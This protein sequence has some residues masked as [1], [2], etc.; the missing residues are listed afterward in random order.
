MSENKPKSRPVTSRPRVG[1]LGTGFISDFHIRCLKAIPEVELSAVCDTDPCK[2]TACKKRWDIPHLFSSLPEMLNSGS[3][4]VVHVL[5]PPVSH[6]EAALTC[7]EHGVDVF[8]EKP[9]GVSTAECDR[10]EDCAGRH[11]RTIGVN[12][13]A[14]H[15]PAFLRL[16]KMIET[17]RLGNIEHVTACINL[18]LRQLSA[19]QHGHWMFREFGNIILE[20][21]PHPLSQ[22]QFLL[23]PIRDCSAVVSGRRRLNT[24]VAFHDTWQISLL[25][26]RGTAQLLLSFGRDYLENSL[27]VIGQDGSA[28]V[29][30]RRNTIQ[31]SEKSRFIDP[32]DNLRDAFQSSWAKVGQNVTNF[33][34]YTLSFL[35][36]RPPSDP[37]LLSIAGS[38]ASFYT[39]LQ[40]RRSPTMGLSEGTG[41]IRACERIVRDAAHNLESHSEKEHEHATA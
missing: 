27:H 26:D 17:W 11:R 4:D 9:V 37:F 32:V 31:V 40:E 19:G 2:A 33:A 29:D 18:P 20:Q 41:V 38:I 35:K 10:L 24:G 1:I 15:Y 16:I 6:A 3:V 12:H 13:N 23:G 5:T 14:V 22:I 30:L 39:A 7:M 34:A 21:G 25:C 36:I 28:L 8:M